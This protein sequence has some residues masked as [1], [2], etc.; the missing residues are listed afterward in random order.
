MKHFI[1]DT[2]QGAIYTGYLTPSGHLP[3]MAVP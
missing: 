2:E 1:D 3:G